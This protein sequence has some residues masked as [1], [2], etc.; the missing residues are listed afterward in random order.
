MDLKAGSLCQPESYFGM[1]MGCVVVDNQMDIEGFRCGPI[2]A[3]E[4]LRNS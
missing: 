2:D 3:L 1:L 4:E